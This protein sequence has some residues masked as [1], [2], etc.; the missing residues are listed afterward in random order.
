[1]TDTTEMA[2]FVEKRLDEFESARERLRLLQVNEAHWN[3]VRIDREP[4]N[5]FANGDACGRYNMA[6][7]M[8]APD[9]AIWNDHPDYQS[10]WD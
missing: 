9:A 3:E 1:M 5:A 4:F 2:A 8:V 7:R 10:A 6:R